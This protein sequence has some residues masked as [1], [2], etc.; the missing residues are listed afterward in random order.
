MNGEFITALDFD[1][2]GPIGGHVAPYVIPP[3]LALCE[4]NAKKG[5]DRITAVAVA[6]EIGGRILASVSHLKVPKDEP[7]YYED[8]PRFS[9]TSAIFGGVAS[10]C[11][12]LDLGAEVVAQRLWY[13]RHWRLK[14][15]L[16]VTRISLTAS[17]ATGRCTALLSLKRTSY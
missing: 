17:S 12:A 13:R 10:A 8:A 5:S 14:K 9:Y 1:L 2:L 4:K 11:K 7:P 6:L 15:G 3:A 16:P